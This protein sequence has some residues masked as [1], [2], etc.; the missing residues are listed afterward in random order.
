MF[1]DV[2][3]FAALG[4]GVLALAAVLVLFRRV[5]GIQ[6]RHQ[7]EVG[8]LIRRLQQLEK[9]EEALRRNLGVVLQA[10]QRIVA[11][12]E[13]ARTLPPAAGRPLSA[14]NPLVKVGVA[15]QGQPE[16]ERPFQPP[17][18]PRVLH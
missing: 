5:D 13:K 7:G 16:E 4:G 11:E 1:P 14:R 17:F 12:M 6:R 18:G 9:N 10:G 2:G 8:R 15:Q 3:V